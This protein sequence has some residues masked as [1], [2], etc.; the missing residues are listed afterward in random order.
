MENENR[1]TT[2]EALQCLAQE[3]VNLQARVTAI[4]TSFTEIAQKMHE[5]TEAARE[6]LALIPKQPPSRLN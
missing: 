4:E 5:V 2:D 1:V 3:I 6:R